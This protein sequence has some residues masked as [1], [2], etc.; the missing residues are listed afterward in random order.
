MSTSAQ[1][2]LPQ[3]NVGLM[4]R[5][6]IPNRIRSVQAELRSL[7]TRKAELTADL[8]TLID[9]AVLHGI[10]LFPQGGSPAARA[11]DPGGTD[12]PPGLAGTGGGLPAS[13]AA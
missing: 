8:R 9:T 4:I 1:P 3:L 10:E 13:R 12:T 5:E 2:T 7:E 6:N 11:S